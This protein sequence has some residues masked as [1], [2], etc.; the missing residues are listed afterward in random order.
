VNE[1]VGEIVGA[2]KSG[3]AKFTKKS[4]AKSAWTNHNPIQLTN[5]TTSK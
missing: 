4:K 1:E 3:V 2:F 5:S